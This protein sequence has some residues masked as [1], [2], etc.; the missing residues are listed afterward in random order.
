M[1][2]STVS[3]FLSIIVNI[4]LVLNW[5][6][7]DMKL[8]SP[9]LKPDIPHWQI[10]LTVPFTYQIIRPWCLWGLQ[11]WLHVQAS[12]SMDNT[13]AQFNARCSSTATSP[14]SMATCACTHAHPA[15]TAQAPKTSA[16]WSSKP[17]MITVSLLCTGTAMAATTRPPA[18]TYPPPT[19]VVHTPSSTWT[20]TCKQPCTSMQGPPVFLLPPCSQPHRYSHLYS[21]LPSQDSVGSKVI[22]EM[23]LEGTDNQCQSLIG[24]MEAFVKLVSGRDFLYSSWITK[25]A[26]LYRLNGSLPSFAIKILLSKVGISTDISKNFLLW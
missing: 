25:T 6:S 9:Q 13:P 20:L 2:F 24:N 17:L 23:I 11:L 26:S 5:T 12:C 14:T 16:R 22:D 15:K 3:I 10:Y 1:H 19:D 7:F 18:H 8:I 4:L 21:W